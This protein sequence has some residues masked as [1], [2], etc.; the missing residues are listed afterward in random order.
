MILF[1]SPVPFLIYPEFESWFGDWTCWGT[2]CVQ[3]FGQGNVWE[4]TLK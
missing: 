3:L 4:S 1:G 2:S